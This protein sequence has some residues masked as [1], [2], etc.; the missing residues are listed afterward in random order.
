MKSILCVAI[1]LLVGQPTLAQQSSENQTRVQ[2]V[3]AD[4]EATVTK[5]VQADGGGCVMVAVFNGNKVVWSKGFGLADVEKNIPATANTIGRTGSISKSFTGVLICQLAEQGV[6]SLDDPVQKHLPELSQLAGMPSDS[7]PITYRMLASHTAGLI[8]EPR[9]RQ[10]MASG[11][12]HLWEEKIIESIPKTSF[13]TKPLT[14][15]S[16]S[17]IGYGIL[18]L[19][20]SRAADKPFMALIEAKI[21]DPLKMESSTFVVESEE[22]KKRL[23]VGYLRN[24]RTGELDSTV[25]TR[26][27][28]GRGYKVPNG[29]IYSTV[30][31][32]AKFAAAMM[33]ESEPELLSAKM[34]EQ[35]LSP[36]QP[37]RG[38]GLGFSIMSQRDREHVVG[39]GGSVSG[40]RA[41]LRFDLKSKWGVATLRTTQY[42]PP[43]QRLLRNLI[44]A[45]KQSGQ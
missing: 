21:F 28:L 24:R 35:A 43:V 3:V 4:F 40:Y 37:A 36:Q 30:G 5:A 10:S 27:H 29:G 26:E 38:Y 15:Y 23:A 41:D 19:A 1:L 42:S 34:R 8:R 13:K 22:M 12:I 17:N 45:G 14:E 6:L 20:G 16:Y 11:P 9:S 7:Q 39:H 2:E 44:S 32:L 33:G 18:G 31:D 25:P